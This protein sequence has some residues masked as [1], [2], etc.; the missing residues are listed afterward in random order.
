MVGKYIKCI[1]FILIGSTTMFADEIKEQS[2]YL[3]ITLIDREMSKDSNSQHYSLEVKDR[4]V[5]YH[6]KYNGFPFPSDREQSNKY[7]LSNI[8]FKKL[9]EQIKFY[10][11]DRNIT[12]LK[13]EKYIGHSVDLSLTLKLDG[14]TTQSHITGMT[15]S[16]RHKDKLISHK[17][18]VDDVESLISNFKKN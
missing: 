3:Q 8:Q 1:L 2:F 10:N 11:I 12:E 16:F 6:Y 13:K 5:T 15:S 7:K 4:D 14:K 18:Y 9:I 17:S